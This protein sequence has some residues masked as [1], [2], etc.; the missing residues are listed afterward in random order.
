M[1]IPQ[2]H[3]I[4]FYDF[5]KVMHYLEEKHGKNFRDYGNRFGEGGKDTNEYLDF[6]HYIIGLNEISNGG[7]ITLP[8]TGPDWDH[9]DWVV[10]ILGYFKEF[11]GDDYDLPMRT[12]W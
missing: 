2:K 5:F 4:K 10:E 8:E 3:K 12:E 1:K 9:P 11:L 7:F 6:W